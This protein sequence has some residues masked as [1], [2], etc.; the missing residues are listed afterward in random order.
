MNNDEMMS[1][2]EAADDKYD[3][4]YKCQ[5]KKNDHNYGYYY[6]SHGLNTA[7]RHHHWI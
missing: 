1:L 5:H 7:I 3:D 6:D 2:P 4:H